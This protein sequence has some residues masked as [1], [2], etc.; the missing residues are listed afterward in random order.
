MSIVFRDDDQLVDAAV[1]CQRCEAVCCRLTVVLMP[2]EVQPAHLVDV[3]HRGLDVMRRSE[4]GWCAAL[5]RV[6]MRCGIYDTRPSICRKF[7][8]GGAYC[9]DERK[10]YRKLTAGRRIPMRLG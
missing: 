10:S 4:D 3:D 8:M 9:R 1:S 2:D 6:Q 5:D 7:A